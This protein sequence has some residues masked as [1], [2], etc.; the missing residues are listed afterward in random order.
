MKPHK[1]NTL[2]NFMAAWYIKPDVC[3]KLIDFYEA[4]P[5]KEK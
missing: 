5:N 4:H 2:N 3:D 1:I